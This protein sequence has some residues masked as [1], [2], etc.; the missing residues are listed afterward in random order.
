[1]FNPIRPELRL[2]LHRERVDEGL[3]RAARVQSSQTP[4][5]HQRTSAPRP[6]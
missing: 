6:A 5:P 2:A 1:M 3:R 4:S